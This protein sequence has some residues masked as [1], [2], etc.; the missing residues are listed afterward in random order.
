MKN[1]LWF[2]AGMMFGEFVLRWIIHAVYLSTIAALV[3]K[4]FFG[5][6]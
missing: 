5:V 3:L 4:I 1:V 2:T 6:H